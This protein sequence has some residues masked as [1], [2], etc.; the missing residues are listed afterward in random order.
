[1]AQSESP[2]TH[3]TCTTE[4]ICVEAYPSFLAPGETNNHGRNYFA[5]RIYIKNMSD[6]PV[7]L[8]SR[9][10]LIINAT[11][12]EQIV[13]GKGVIGYTPYLEPGQSFEYTSYCPIDTDW[14]TMEGYYTFVRQDRT[15]FQ[16]RIERFYLVVPDLIDAQ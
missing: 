8:L 7:Q 15:T 12:A 14:G 5:Y 3:S 9:K 16:V 13:E 1:M 10:W 11:G 2:R 6:D 4:G